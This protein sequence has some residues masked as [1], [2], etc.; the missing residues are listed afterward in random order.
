M[1]TSFCLWFLSPQ[2]VNQ[3]ISLITQNFITKKTLL[4]RNIVTLETLLLNTLRENTDNTQVYDIVQKYM[5]N[6]YGFIRNIWKIVILWGRGI[7]FNDLI[8]LIY[9]TDDRPL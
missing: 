5:S 2:S 9:T 7:L 3:D 4:P 1:L 6:A 8:T